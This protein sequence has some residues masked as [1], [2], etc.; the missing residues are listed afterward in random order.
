MDSV[1]TLITPIKT[2]NSIGAFATTSE[3][4]ITIFGTV[5]S[6]NRTEWYDAGQNGLNPEIVFTTPIVN[7]SGQ[8]IAEY[9]GNRYAIYRTYFPND[10]DLIELYLTR[11]V[12][13]KSAT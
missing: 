1:L 8:T 3:E 11:D 9:N 4:S 10:S 5:S 7:Y 6:I 13:T 2:Q 12:G